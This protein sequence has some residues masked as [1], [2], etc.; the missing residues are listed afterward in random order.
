MYIPGF[1]YLVATGWI[2]DVSLCEN[3]INQKSTIID[4]IEV[5]STAS[6][7][8]KLEMITLTYSIEPMNQN[9]FKEKSERT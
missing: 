3:S 9:V 5:T 8:S 6:K 2:F 1:F 4:Y 7:R